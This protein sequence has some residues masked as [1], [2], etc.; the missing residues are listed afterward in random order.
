MKTTTLREDYDAALRLRG[1]RRHVTVTDSM[2]PDSP[3][4]T[5]DGR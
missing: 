1:T 2:I 4:L 5:A 3:K